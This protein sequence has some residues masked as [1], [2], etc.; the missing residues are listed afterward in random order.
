[1]GAGVEQDFEEAY[2]WL[3]LAARSRRPPKW[4]ESTKK[5]RDSVAEPLSPEALQRAD[6]RVESFSTRR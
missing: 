5:L 1:M 6:E 4:I 3:S 2:F